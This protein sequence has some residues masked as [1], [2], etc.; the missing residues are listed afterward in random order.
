MHE[1]RLPVQI[2]PVRLAETGRILEGQL[3]LSELTR[4]KDVLVDNRGTVAVRLEFGID[5]E[6]IPYLKGQIRSR[7][8]LACQ[9]CLLPMEHEIDTEILLG[10][11][12]SEEAV[13]LLPSHYEPL[14]VENGPLYLKDLIEDE[15]LLSLPIVPM[16]PESECAV[17][18]RELKDTERG[19]TEEPERKSPFS[20]LAGMKRK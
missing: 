15:L 19:K 17:G 18:E 12:E 11:A 4:L 16:H 5:Q 7:V 20:V 2:D 1:E 14:V 6:G 9:R 8:T 13:Q 10:I 3:P